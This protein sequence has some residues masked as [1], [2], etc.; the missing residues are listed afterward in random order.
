MSISFEK[1]DLLHLIDAPQDLGH[2]LVQAYDKKVQN[3]RV[4]GSVFEIKFRGT[5]WV[6]TGTDTVQTRLILLTLFECLEQRGFS[7]YAS[8]KQDNRNNGGHPSISAPDT[9]FFN[10]QAD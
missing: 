4:K 8:I 6:P 3:H 10:R 9:L 7:L 2:A 5:P 1:G